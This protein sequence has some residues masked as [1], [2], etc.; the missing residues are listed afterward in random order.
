L[1]ISSKGILRNDQDVDD[2]RI[3]ASVVEGPKSGALRLKE[4]GSFTYNSEANFNGDDF[5]AYEVSDTKGDTDT[6]TAKIT[7]KPDPDRPT[8]DAGG[9]YFVNEGDSVVVSASGNDP[10]GGELTYKW[11]LDSDGSFETLGKSATYSAWGLDGPVTYDIAVKVIDAEGASSVA[12]SSVTVETLLSRC[13][14][15]CWS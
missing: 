10:D 3:T 14:H 2:D 12:E 15:T 1:R 13:K 6:A 4:D 5:F 11:D 8:A 9:P 7:V